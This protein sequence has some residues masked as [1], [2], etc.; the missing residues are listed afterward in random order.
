M[1]R[2]SLSLLTPTRGRPEQ[3]RRYLR[4]VTDTANTPSAIE[5]VSYID[6]DDSLMVR[7]KDNILTEFSEIDIRFLEGKRLT[8][9]EANQA[10]YEASSGE[11]LM[12]NGDDI[13]FR[14]PNWDKH[15]EEAFEKLPAK[16]GLV[17]ADDGAWHDRFA[18]HPAVSRTWCDTLGYLCNGL[19]SADFDDS[20]IYDIARR[21]NNISNEKRII[22]S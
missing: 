22:I 19:F 15:F 3:Y 10:C 12:L 17:F 4:S 8:L 7:E 1:K 14:T 16:I 2:P 11:I 18:T 21:L 13:L 20:W 6:D 5:I 9:S